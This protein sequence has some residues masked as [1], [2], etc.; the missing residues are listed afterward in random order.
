MIPRIIHQTSRTGELSPS[1]REYQQRV[2]DLH[3]GWEYRHWTDRDNMRLVETQAP[4]LLGLYR[5]LPKNI[6]R[7]DMVRYIY[8][9][10]I[11]GLYL[12]FDY[13]FLKPFD[14]LDK[15]LVVPRENDDT[16]ETYL[17]NSV[18][19]SEAHHPF[20]TDVL[21]ELARSVSSLR[22]DPLEDEITGLTGPGLLT[23]VYKRKAGSYAELH[24][25][26]RRDFNPSYFSQE[27]HEALIRSGVSYGIHHSEGTWRAKTVGQRAL[28]KLAALRAGR[29][30]RR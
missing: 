4:A 21:A 24:F 14:L 7:A 6:M 28:R 15:R 12:D 5:A 8:M 3:P 13:E 20:W 19:A 22:R 10:T 26:S 23:R 9:D 17:G 1:W 18:L 16:E 30:E 2:R 25:G 27:E 11:G 29:K